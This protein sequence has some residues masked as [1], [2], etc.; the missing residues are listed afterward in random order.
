VKK[1]EDNVSRAVKKERWHRLNE[2]L[3]E[4]S[5]ANNQIEIGTTK[6]VMVKEVTDDRITGYSENMKQVIVEREA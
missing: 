3:K 1:Y 5:A 6:T 2:V 4:V